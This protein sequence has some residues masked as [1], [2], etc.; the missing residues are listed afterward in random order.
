MSDRIFKTEEILFKL[1]EAQKRAQIGSWEWDIKNDTVWWSDEMYNIL[2][3]N[4]DSYTPKYDSAAQYVHHEDN[5]NYYKAIQ[6]SIE[7]RTALD[8]EMRLIINGKIKYCNSRATVEYDR[9]GKPDKI[10]GTLMDISDRKNA[11][12]EVKQSLE[13]L[14][15][16]AALV[17]GVIYQYRLYPDG[18]SAFPY[19]SPGM[20]TIYEVTP[21]EVKYDATPVFS[22]LHPDDYD[23]I[24]YLIQK[25][26]KELCHFHVEFRVNL[27][28]QGLKWRLSDA[29]PQKLDDGSILWHGII[30]DITD[31]KIAEQAAEAERERLMVTLRSIG[32]GVI[33]TDIEGN[34]LIM[35]KVAEELTGW[36]QCE[37]AGK[38]FS[39]VFII[40]NEFTEKPCEDP[41]LK[42]ISTGDV[43]EIENH[44]LLVSRDGTR[45]TIS[46]S[47][48][49]IKDKNNKIIGVVLVFRDMTEKQKLI[50]NSQ[51]A[52]KLNS[53]GVLAG[54]I[55]HDFNNLLG[56]IFGYLEMAKESSI[57]G[58]ET[59]LYLDKALSVFNRA[60]DLTQQLLTFSKGG[61]PKRTAGNL[62]TVVSDTVTF[63]LA[64]SNIAPEIF[65]DDKLWLCDYDENQI[66]QVIDNLVINA[67]QAMPD[68]GKICVKA[69]NMMINQG[70][71][72]TLKPG[73]YVKISISDS[74]VGI[75]P[76][77][78]KLIF[79][80]FFTTK[81][82][83]SGLG[84]ATA[85][86]I[87]KRHDGVI[88]VKSTS[89][90]GSTF[91]V[92]LPASDR[93]QDLV[94]L[95]PDQEHSGS[96]VILIM[97]DEAFIR[98]ILGVLLKKMG[99]SIVE[100]RDGLEAVRKI[101]QS[102]ENDL[103]FK[104][105]IFDL[106]VPGGFG[107]KEAVTI[108]REKFKDFPVFASSGYS[109]NPIMANPGEYGFLDSIRKPYRMID[110]AGL[111]N[112][113]LK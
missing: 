79:D 34:I 20:F 76:E 110:L 37:A 3:L 69:E 12:I 105:A 91:T 93:N 52:D 4:P 107:G 50:E 46:D 53:I 103:P 22:R 15:N 75:S 6:K 7:E 35:N 74:G 48:A 9:A 24:V 55:A 85:Y 2:E 58:S 56:G 44:T 68:G 81:S 31:R 111:F 17:P 66:S 29:V 27:P 71:H 94:T 70:D 84:L 99:Y 33:A 21:E 64:G 32:D 83:G 106:T 80:P 1:N 95:N 51:K 23:N 98:E 60:K 11:E 104:C 16:L 67:K 97:D 54:G 78:L 96:G 38:P 10:S 89:G 61:A 26:A 43:I 88:D 36:T 25:S 73:A 87:I 92:Y 109:E 102:F 45:R 72:H 13:L 100:A 86:S 101:E 82:K 42:V 47:G 77:N 40:I 113:H 18:R 112:K 90:K 59:E 63:A 28:K 41:Y 19:S 108:I 49:P 8:Y 57:N 65:I 14:T 62:K 5:E 39:E 30:S